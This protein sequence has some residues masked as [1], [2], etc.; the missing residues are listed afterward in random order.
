MCKTKLPL[1]QA[2]VGVRIV[3]CS[4]AKI[5]LSLQMVYLAP[6]SAGNFGCQ[7]GICNSVGFREIIGLAE[8]TSTQQAWDI[9][10]HRSAPD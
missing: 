1:S 2:T 5:D 10:D 7:V 8:R 4:H 6:S 9:R 3:F